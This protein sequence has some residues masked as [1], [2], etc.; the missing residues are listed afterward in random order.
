MES[1]K[2]FTP[3]IL[4]NGNMSHFFHRD[5]G[6]GAS[7]WIFETPLRPTWWCQPMDFGHSIATNLVVPANGYR[8]P[9]R[10][11]DGASQW[12]IPM[13]DSKPWTAITILSSSM[14][15]WSNYGASHRILVG[16]HRLT[17]TALARLA[18]PIFET[19]ECHR[20]CRWTRRRWCPQHWWYDYQRVD[21]PSVTRMA[22]I[23][24]VPSMVMH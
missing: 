3:L 7:Q 4:E 22:I 23:W 10:L 17:L 18:A 11:V 5:Q 9:L 21:V 24:M 19:S 15:P 20:R 6:G 13:R 1:I 12:I 14:R 2:R 16:F 8:A